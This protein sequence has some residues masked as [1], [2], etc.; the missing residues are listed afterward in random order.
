MLGISSP[1]YNFLENNGLSCVIHCRPDV[2][3][4]NTN[5]IYFSNSFFRNVKTEIISD[6]LMQFGVSVRDRLLNLISWAKAVPGKYL[7]KYN[8]QFFNLNKLFLSPGFSDMSLPTQT[9]A[10]RN[11]WLDALALDFAFYSQ[12]A[13]STINQQYR[14]GKFQ[15]FN[16]NLL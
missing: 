10:L 12:P 13:T 3:N 6:N 11:G 14:I 16:P 2:N 15:I 1:R 7:N 9:Q 5:S 4:L 8:R